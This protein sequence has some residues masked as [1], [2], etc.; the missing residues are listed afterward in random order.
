[1]KTTDVA[2]STHTDAPA[3]AAASNAKREQAIGLHS[4]LRRRLLRG[5]AAVTP[6]MLTAI[7]SPVMATGQ[8]TRTA[9]RFASHSGSPTNK[10][11]ALP[12]FREE[13]DQETCTKAILE[14]CH[15]LNAGLLTRVATSLS[16]LLDFQKYGG[17]GPIAYGINLA[18]LNTLSLGNAFS[19]VTSVFGPTRKDSS[20]LGI[21]GSQSYEI[22]SVEQMLLLLLYLNLKVTPALE[23][24]ICLS[25]ADCISIAQN[26]FLSGHPN[27]GTPLDV[28]AYLKAL[29]T[30]N[31]RVKVW[32]MRL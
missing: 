9:S 6:V 8:C 17:A 18:L 28:T 22:T 3:P 23:A 16:T 29:L 30:A 14:L 20:L 12:N 15:G 26:G 13:F 5:G 24:D 27:L 21:L 4:P 31:A 7:S 10:F 1:M 2:A 32:G 25:A 11:T 19:T